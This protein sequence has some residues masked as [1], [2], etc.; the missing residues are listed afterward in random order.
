MNRKQFLVWTAIAAL[1]AATTLPANAADGTTDQTEEQKKLEQLLAAAQKICPVTG[2]DLKSMGGPV[3]A[4]VAEQSLFLCCKGCLNGRINKQ[5]AD[6]IDKNLIA[7][8][9][10]CPVMGKELPG[11]PDSLAVKGRKI[12]VC[13]PPCTDKI[14][15]DPDKHLAAVNKLLQEHLEAGGDSKPV[16]QQ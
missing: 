8:Q 9:G 14:K 13:C 10:K 16:S 2:K 5:H 1:V 11:A 7:A 3:K 15:A 4:T 6:Q 12:F